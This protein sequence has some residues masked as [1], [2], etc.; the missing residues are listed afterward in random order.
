MTSRVNLESFINSTIANIQLSTSRM[1]K[2]QEAI[3]SG[4]KIN[5]PSDNAG[6]AVK[7]INLR[8]EDLRLEQ[9]SSNIQDSIKSLEFNTSALQN[10]SN[11]IQRVQEL[12]IQGANSAAGQNER[13]AVASEINQILESIL[14]SANTTRAGR[15][16]FAGTK[17][18][19]TPF[20]VTRNTKGEIATV[21]YKGNREKIEYQI[22]PGTSTQ[23]NQPGEEVFIDNKLFGT[24]IKIRDNLA[25]GTPGLASG[26]LDN[27]ENAQKSVFNLISKGGAIA[28]TLELTN[29]RIEETKLSIK[30]MLG[31]TESADLTKLV[32]K[33]KEEENI[34]QASLASGT[35][36][37][38]TSILDFL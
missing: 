36:I 8:S 16:I 7:I 9:Y 34:F 26:E 31:S 10:V 33:L 28:N 15:Y 21:T 2:L 13:D 1:H 14:M 17:T 27:L 30:D 5:I 25:D 6:D 38:K 24:I 23:I 37:F 32:L 3:S 20:E 11:L 29:N 35:L 18:T 4:K 22:G 19:T 12:T